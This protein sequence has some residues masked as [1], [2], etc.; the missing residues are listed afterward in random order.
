MW[1]LLYCI[2]HVTSIYFFPSK[3][4]TKFTQAFVKS[5]CIV[6]KIR[7]SSEI[8][9]S[10]KI[11]KREVQII[12]TTD[13]ND[14]SPAYLRQHCIV[15]DHTVWGWRLGW[16]R[17]GPQDS[18]YKR[19]LLQLSTGLYI[20]HRYGN[21]NNLYI[22]A[23]FKNRY[24]ALMNR[25]KYHSLVIKTSWFSKKITPIAKYHGRQILIGYKCNL[26]YPIILK[27]FTTGVNLLKVLLL[28]QCF[29]VTE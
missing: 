29:T 1:V 24:T 20:K 18:L 25:E 12:L 10:L 3:K 2:L 27:L 5:N 13:D 19:W 15:R 11:I 26:S 9:L 22:I 21:I 8:N 4:C 14:L 6:L 23:Y 16:G 17:S 28:Y 7:K